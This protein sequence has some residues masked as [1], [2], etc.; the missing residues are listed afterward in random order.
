[1][2]WFLRWSGLSLAGTLLFLV[3]CS[4]VGKELTFDE[5]SAVYRSFDEQRAWSHLEKQ[6]AFGPRPAGSKA[7][8]DTRAFLTKTLN[9]SGWA[10]QEQAFTDSTPR[11]DIKFV[12]LRARFG[13][14]S[15]FRRSVTGLIGSHIDTKIFDE[16]EFVGANDAGSSTAVL[17]E[18]ARAASGRPA[19]AQQLELIFFDG[20]EAFVNFTA[21]DGLYGSR[22]YARGLRSQSPDKK[23]EFAIILD[24]VGDRDLTITL[25]SDTPPDLARPLFAAA[26]DLGFR[27]HFGF[28]RTAILDDHVP[29]QAA[30][31]PAM[32][33][34][35]FDYPP[36]HKQTD[37]IDKLK[38]ESLGVIGQT[39]LLLLEKYLLGAKKGG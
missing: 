31:V 22:H 4:P 26:E 39:T 12:N 11:G 6:L 14:D 7:L 29:L 25:P 1:M 37:T 24:M 36:W 3:G 9:A 19:L 23:P 30:G 5:P 16:F 13:G 10:V 27:S 32:D 17:L 33:I 38:A 15:A 35:D 18:I 28:F 21:T 2:F 20:E 8:D 34:I